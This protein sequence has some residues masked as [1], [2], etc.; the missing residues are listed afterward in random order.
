MY[1]FRILTY[2]YLYQIAVSFS[3]AHNQCKHQTLNHYIF[4]V[5]SPLNLPS[6]TEVFPEINYFFNIFKV[7]KSNCKTDD[8]CLS[9][10]KCCDNPLDKYNKMC[11]FGNGQKLVTH[12]SMFVYN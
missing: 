9:P 3:D 6:L 4:N 5:K 1:F 11:C 8:D 2:L 12:K 10:L 7:K